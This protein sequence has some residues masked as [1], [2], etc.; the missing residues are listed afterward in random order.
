DCDVENTYDRHER[1]TDWGIELAHVS[2][3]RIRRNPAEAAAWLVGRAAAAAQTTSPPKGLVV[4][5]RG[6]LLR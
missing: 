3:R 2:V 5:P 4:V 6:P 1:I